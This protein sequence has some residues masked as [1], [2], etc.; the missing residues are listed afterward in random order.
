VLLC[1]ESSDRGSFTIP[2][3]ALS[4]LPAADASAA[5]LFVAPHP[6]SNPVTI[7]GLDFAYFVNMSSDYEAVEFR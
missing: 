4:A 1:T 5:F 7:P 6:F 2:D 3:F